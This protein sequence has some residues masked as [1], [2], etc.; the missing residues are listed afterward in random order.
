MIYFYTSLITGLHLFV[1][2][3]IVVPVAQADEK[4]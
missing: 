3:L 2:I 4:G 1:I